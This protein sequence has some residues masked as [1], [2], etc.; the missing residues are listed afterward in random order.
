MKTSFEQAYVYKGK[1]QKRGQKRGRFYL[2][3][4]GDFI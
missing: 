1:G 2:E 4:A 3:N